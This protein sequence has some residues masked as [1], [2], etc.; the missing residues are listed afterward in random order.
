VVTFLL[1]KPRTGR[2]GSVFL[3]VFSRVRLVQLRTAWFA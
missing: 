2:C 1:N 3:P